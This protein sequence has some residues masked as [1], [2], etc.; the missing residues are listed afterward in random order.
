MLGEVCL[1][2]TETRTGPIL[3][4]GLGDVV[5]DAMKAALAH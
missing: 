5:F 2:L 3:E 1:E 4:P